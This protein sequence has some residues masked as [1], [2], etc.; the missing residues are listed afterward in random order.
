LPHSILLEIGHD[1]K[2]SKKMRVLDPKLPV[3]L[4]EQLRRVRGK[5][6]PAKTI[7]LKA[8]KYTESKID[9][10]IEIQTGVMHQIR[11]HLAHLGFP[12]LG[13]SIYRGKPSSR[14]WLHAWK[15]HLNGR[16]IEAPLPED[17]ST[18]KPF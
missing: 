13:D 8:L 14:L 7:L 9:F 18:E 4:K 1:L 6:Q 5:P 10:E 3:S 12:L 2:S 17:W 15:L 11:A 16:W